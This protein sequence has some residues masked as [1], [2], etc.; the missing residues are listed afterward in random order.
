MERGEIENLFKRQGEKRLETLKTKAY[1]L[2]KPQHTIP[3]EGR[4]KGPDTSNGDQTRFMVIDHADEL[5]EERNLRRNVR[6][7]E[8]SPV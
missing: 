1:R 6:A 2:K 4:D 5:Y 8:Q 7:K 3:V